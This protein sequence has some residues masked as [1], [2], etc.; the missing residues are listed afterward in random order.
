[1]ADVIAGLRTL[2]ILCARATWSVQKGL[3]DGGS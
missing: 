1:M 2:S 3:L